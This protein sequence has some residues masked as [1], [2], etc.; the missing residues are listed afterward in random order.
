MHPRGHYENGA[1]RHSLKIRQ[2]ARSESLP[3]L[4]SIV[5]PPRSQNYVNGFARANSKVDALPGVLAIKK[6]TPD[7][8]RIRID[9]W[10]SESDFLD[11]LRLNPWIISRKFESATL[12]K[13]LK[14][15]FEK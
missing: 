12:L 9:R 15:K 5:T 7:A 13:N 1:D 6:A 10:F 4:L 8:E 3:L 2:V 14:P 11:V